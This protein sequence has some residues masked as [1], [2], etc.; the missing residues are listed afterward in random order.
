MNDLNNPDVKQEDSGQENASGNMYSYR[1]DNQKAQ[2]T[3]AIRRSLGEGNPNVDFAQNN[4]GSGY[5]QNYVNNGEVGLQYSQQDNN[6]LDNNSSYYLTY[7]ILLFIEVV[8]III[9][10]VFFLNDIK[11]YED[12][13][14]IKKFENILFNY[15]L[16]RDMNVMV[17]FGFGILH[18][19]LRRNAWLSISINTLL[20]A[21][22][23]QFSI[24]FNFLWKTAFKEEWKDEYL[25]ISYLMR[26]IFISCS[27]VISLGCVSGKLSMIQ[28]LIM[29]IFE[30]IL[31][32]LNYQLCE[33][34]LESIDVGGALYIHTFGAIFGISMSM[35]LF[36]SKKVK[37]EIQKFNYLYKSNYFSSLT[38]FL[39]IIILFCFFPSFNSALASI[40]K[41]KD[42]LEN[43]SKNFTI[44]KEI[45][46]QRQRGR[47]NTYFS[48]FG[49][50]ISSF[51]SSGLFNKGRFVFEQILFGSI[52]GAIII[53]GCCTVCFDHWA[54]IIIGT[55]GSCITVIFLSKIKPLFN[56]CG[57]QDTFNV[58]I[59][60]GISG[61]LGSFITS[62]FV[63]NFKMRFYNV[64]TKGEKY[65]YI[66]TDFESRVDNN[67]QAGVQIGAIFI[68][69]G[70]SFIGGIATGYLMKISTC[71]KLNQYFTDA[72]FF[73]EEEN[74][75]FNYI[76]QNTIPNVEINN[77]SLF[78]KKM[79]FPHYEN[80][81]TKN[82]E[83][84]GNQPSYFN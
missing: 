71:G 52:S 21:I 31:S 23:I 47:I 54:A 41:N 16:F 7:I 24:F 55:L 29:T 9:L 27:V 49:S 35:V 15:G 69:I 28:Y 14:E 72:E 66:Y 8:I 58:V 74:N 76:E 20:I 25:D 2:E 48:L 81:R 65:K 30:S 32:C 18:S 77:P 22:S 3:G 5:N 75:I 10:T 34:K 56:K 80:P 1:D 78:P 68:T 38:A 60:H 4:F 64:D 11:L 59:I 13:K 40:D 50:A 39:G 70:I 62:M 73:K 51:I 67:V 84:G 36:C 83:I 6:N 33:E 43:I 26:S 63:G 12:E 19:I 42:K 61:L 82:P 44:V 57:F 53:S 79:E 17:F 45:E 46:L 37:N